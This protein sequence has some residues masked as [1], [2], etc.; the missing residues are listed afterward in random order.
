MPIYMASIYKLHS[1]DAEF[2]Y[3]L[4][5]VWMYVWIVI[6][7]SGPSNVAEIPPLPHRTQADIVNG[8][9]ADGYARTWCII[10]RGI[11]LI[12]K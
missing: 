9:T 2:R 6:L 11:G 5:D 7:L 12:V 1:Y 4:Y 8:M 10:K 3:L